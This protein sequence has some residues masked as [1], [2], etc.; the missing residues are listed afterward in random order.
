M[1]SL[2]RRSVIVAVI[3]LNKSM[4]SIQ[5]T[6]PTN[7]HVLARF[8]LLPNYRYRLNAG[9][10]IRVGVDYAW[11]AR[12]ADFVEAERLWTPEDIENNLENLLLLNVKSAKHSNQNAVCWHGARTEL[13]HHVV[14]R[15]NRHLRSRK[16]NL[17]LSRHIRAGMGTSSSAQMVCLVVHPS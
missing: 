2:I 16:S 8:S 3:T 6:R 14:F 17:M 10:E 4:A 5:I 1:V 13:H 12:C 7:R 15:V 9:T 11:C